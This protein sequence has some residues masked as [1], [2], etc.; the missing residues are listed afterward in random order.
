LARAGCAGARLGVQAVRIFGLPAGR[1]TLSL[2]QVQAMIHPDDRH[3]QQEVLQAALQSSQRYDVEYRIVR[4]DGEVRFVPVW[5]EIEQDPA[6][7]RV[8]L[9]E[10]IQD[11]TE[12][13]QAEEDLRRHATHL[14]CA[15]LWQETLGMPVTLA[16]FDGQLIKA[17]RA[18]QMAYLPS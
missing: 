8:R 1:S 7:R 18:V 12:R 5:D 14:A 4:P 11:I 2:A 6:S 9:F 15:L 13:K 10:T 17:A 16:S 3:L